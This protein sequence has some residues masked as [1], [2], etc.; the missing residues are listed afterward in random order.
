MTHD[1]GLVEPAILPPTGR[2]PPAALA[3]E[4]GEPVNRV[5][6]VDVDGDDVTFTLYDLPAVLS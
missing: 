3:S 1:E 2:R 4:A 6:E 5:P